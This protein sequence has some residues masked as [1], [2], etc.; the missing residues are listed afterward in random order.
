[1]NE[2]KNNLYIYKMCV[3]MYILRYIVTQLFMTIVSKL[4][5]TI[6]ILD[7]L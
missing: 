2:I 3:Y 7:N 5:V 4:N 6:S 1:M